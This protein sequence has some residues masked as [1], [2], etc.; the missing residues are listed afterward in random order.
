MSVRDLIPWGRATGSVPSA[1]RDRDPFVALHREVNRLF[2][3]TFRSFS[4][5]SLLRDGMNWPSIEVGETDKD[6][7]VTAELPGLEEKD[8][9]VTLANGVL[10]IR[11]E[12][13]SETKDE[14]RHFSEHS[15]GRFERRIPI[16][17]EV[18]PDAVK[19]SFRNG[20]LTVTIPKPEEAR[21][22]AKRIPINAS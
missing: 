9:D 1:S 4:T 22:E 7:C 10:A 6:L 12:K 15:Y 19:A 2:E 20:V 13:T 14:E 8:A 18:D 21:I 3:D 11:G 5:P 16:G 17:W